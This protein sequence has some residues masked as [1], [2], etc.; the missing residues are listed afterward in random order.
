MSS[1]KS[2]SLD[3]PEKTTSWITSIYSTIWEE[4]DSPSPLTT[5]YQNVHILWWDM[6]FKNSFDIYYFNM[7][8]QSTSFSDYLFLS[9]SSVFFTYLLHHFSTSTCHLHYY[10][11]TLPLLALLVNFISS[12][13]ILKSSH[14][15]HVASEFLATFYWFLDAVNVNVCYR[16]QDSVYIMKDI[17]NVC[18]IRCINK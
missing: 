2:F 1:S 6:F 4:V 17:D 10:S 16:V 12:F 7:V 3:I 14:S 18:Y 11:A 13:L 9:F 5:H 8:H 15:F